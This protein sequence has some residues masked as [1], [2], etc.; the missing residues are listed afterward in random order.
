MRANEV[1]VSSGK[2]AVLSMKPLEEDGSSE[3]PAG[4]TKA[5]TV[6]GWSH[7][8]PTVPPG[9]VSERT[10]AD[11]KLTPNS[12]NEEDIVEN[13][14]PVSNAMK[15]LREAQSMEKGAEDSVGRAKKLVQHAEEEVIRARETQELKLMK[16]REQ[17]RKTAN[18]P[19]SHP[20]GSI[21][22]PWTSADSLADQKEV[23]LT[24]SAESAEQRAKAA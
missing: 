22:H 15:R 16:N 4:M 20:D 24:E 3:V 11:G 9:G 18:V 17:A 12:H 10:D 23:V 1:D 2:A 21:W 14:A 19:A 7:V 8:V 6:R 13:S 5:T